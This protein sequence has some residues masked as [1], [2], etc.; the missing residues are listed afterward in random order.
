MIEVRSYRQDMPSLQI[1]ITI[2]MEWDITQRD[3][4]HAPDII[5]WHI[6]LAG[7]YTN[8]AEIVDSPLAFSLRGLKGPLIA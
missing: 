7:V 2:T 4:R 8:S 3:I 6:I 1:I 5:A